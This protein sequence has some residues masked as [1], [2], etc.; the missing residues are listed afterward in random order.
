[1]RLDE[2]YQKENVL[3][4]NAMRRIGQELYELDG[5]LNRDTPNMPA[6]LRRIDDIRKALVVNDVDHYPKY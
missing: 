5:Y 2:L 1:M 4:H 3:L 6:A